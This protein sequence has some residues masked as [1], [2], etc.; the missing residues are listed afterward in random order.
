VIIELSQSHLLY[1]VHIA[2]PG[3]GQAASH[4]CTTI[5]CLNNGVLKKLHTTKKG[6]KKDIRTQERHYKSDYT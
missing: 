2:Y 3:L 5:K 4:P 1:Y 6:N